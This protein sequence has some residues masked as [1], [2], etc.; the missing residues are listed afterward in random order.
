MHDAPPKGASR[1]AM[2]LWS[3][4]AAAFPLLFTYG[5]CLKAIEW[6][7]D[8]NRRPPLETVLTLRL[9]LA[10]PVAMCALAAAWA[11]V[12]ACIHILSGSTSRASRTRQL[13]FTAATAAAG[14]MPVVALV[15]F[16]SEDPYT[17]D[18][19]PA[20]RL[21]TLVLGTT[22]LTAIH[23]IPALLIVR[24]Q[25]QALRERERHHAGAS[26]DSN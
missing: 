18:G 10:V 2:I 21:V 23:G 9:L 8:E 12:H 25:L 3:L 22:F 7:P 1:G 24:G 16:P 15:V 17:G 6:W 19:S 5:M 11:L 13:L 4:M 20:A 14:Y 26:L